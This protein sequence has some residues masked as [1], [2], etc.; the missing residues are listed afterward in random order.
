MKEVYNLSPPIASNSFQ[1]RENTCNL[2]NLQL[3]AKT[4]KKTV[5]RDLETFSTLNFSYAILFQKKSGILSFFQYLSELQN[6]ILCI[7]RVLSL[8]FS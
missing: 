2:R 7:V 5:N 4:K 3:L 1:N 8:F 6:F